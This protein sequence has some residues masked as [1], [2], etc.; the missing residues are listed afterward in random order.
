MSCWPTVLAAFLASLV[1]F[2]EALTIVLAVGTVR[3]WRL[4]LLG[5]VA[6]AGVLGLL[7]AIF[8][9]SPGKPQFAAL[10]AYCRNPASAIC[11]TLVAQSDPA[12]GWGSG[13]AR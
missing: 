2:V 6:V 8:W 1:E 9:T 7:T 12:S 11:P 5:T 13:I 3:G 4:A 10:Q